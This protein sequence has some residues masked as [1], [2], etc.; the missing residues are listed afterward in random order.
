MLTRQ[1]IDHISPCIF[2][3]GET[4]TKA[5]VYILCKLKGQHNFQR[6]F[7]IAINMLNLNM[8]LNEQ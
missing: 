2:D 1:R 6:N 4:V 8:S 7:A 5:C 3:D